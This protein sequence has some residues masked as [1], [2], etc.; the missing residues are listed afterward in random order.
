VESGIWFDRSG[1]RKVST[2]TG[3]DVEHAVER[4]GSLKKSADNVSSIYLTLVKAR[5]QPVLT[6]GLSR[7]G[8]PGSRWR[9]IGH[10]LDYTSAD[11]CGAVSKMAKLIYS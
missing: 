10:Q 4:R 3:P 7:K 6:S 8:G 5:Y 2:N 9:R 1:H 11:H